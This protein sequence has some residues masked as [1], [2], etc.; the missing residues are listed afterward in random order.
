VPEIKGNP[1]MENGIDSSSFQRMDA[2]ERDWLLYSRIHSLSEK[3]PLRKIE[4]SKKFAPRSWF[5]YAGFMMAGLCIGVGIYP[6]KAIAF[7]KLL[8]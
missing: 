6:D 4:C 3:C 7:L 8:L 5:L 1:P 2:A